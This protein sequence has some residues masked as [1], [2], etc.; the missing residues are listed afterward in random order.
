MG[1]AFFEEALAL[2]ARLARRGQ[3]VSHSLQTNGLLIDERWC[4]LLRDAGVLVGL[5]LDGPEHVHDRHRRMAGGQPTGRRVQDAARRMLDA[6]VAVNA[7]AVVNAYSARFP[8]EIYGFLKDAGLVHMQFIPCFERDRDGRAAPFSVQPEA[9]GEF[10][11]RVFDCW[12]ADFDAYGPTVFVRWFDSVFATYVG[13]SPP[14]CTLQSVCGDYVVIEH[15]GDV[16]VCDFFVEEDWRLGN[17]HDSTL[18][19]MLNSP[20]QIAFGRRKAALPEACQAC[21]WLPHCR[22][23]CPKDRRPGAAAPGPSHS[24]EAYQRFFEHADGE[25]RALADDWQRRQSVERP[26]V[27]DLAPAAKLRSGRN[28]PCPCGSGRKFK[29]CCGRQDSRDRVG[30]RSIHQD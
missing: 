10:L 22:G 21:R 23:G 16:Y 28:D 4:R 1:V 17:V 26:S 30:A 29:R 9:L 24:C 27:M 18:L 19:E 2:Q 15:N 3:V 6:G 12:R 25:M 13:V 8:E 7:L 14:E 5:S 11:C 20:R